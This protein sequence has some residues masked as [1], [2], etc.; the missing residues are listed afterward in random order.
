MLAGIMKKHNRG[1]T[2]AAAF[3][4][5]IPVLLGYLALGTAYG[6]VLCEAGLPWWMAPL[7]GVLIY[8][9]AG[10][11]LAAALLAAG[12][13]LAELVIAE[14]VLNARHIAYGISL[15]RRI[16]ETGRCKWYLIYALT[17]E[18]FALISGLPEDLEP[19]LDR[20]RLMVYIAALD[21][22]YWVGGSLIGAAAGTLIPFDFEG[23]GFALTA[24]FVALMVEQ[25]RRLKRP[26]PFVIAVLVSALTALVL[27]ARFTLPVSLVV[28]IGMA[29]YA[30][31]RRPEGT[32]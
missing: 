28:S 30:E 11:F 27:P 9:G 6:L 29:Q 18:T 31:S 19:A 3:R 7:S 1:K 15:R 4:Y 10:Q 5:S 23:V 22:C 2:F 16:G 14:L 26:G 17:D 24:L 32:R 20:T 21:H 8:A 25:I 12:A 13:G